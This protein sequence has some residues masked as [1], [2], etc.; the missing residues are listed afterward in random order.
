[1]RNNKKKKGEARTLPPTEDT[2][3]HYLI[4]ILYEAPVAYHEPYM[5]DPTKFVYEKVKSRMMTQSPSPP[6]LLNDLVC[7]CPPN[8]CLQTCKCLVNNQSCTNACR[9]N[10]TVYGESEDSPVC[11]NFTHQALLTDDNVSDSDTQIY[12]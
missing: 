12:I 10:A 3:V 6:E 8:M 11:K 4:H 7:S 1:M 5:L 2:K 9:C